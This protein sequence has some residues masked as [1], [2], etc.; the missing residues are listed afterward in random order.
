MIKPISLSVGFFRRKLKAPG[1]SASFLLFL[2]IAFSS[3]DHKSDLSPSLF[4]ASW[5]GQGRNKRLKNQKFIGNVW[6]EIGKQPLKGPDKRD[7]KMLIC[8]R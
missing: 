7:N 5:R 3:S 1:V 4:E 6:D 8:G 2:V